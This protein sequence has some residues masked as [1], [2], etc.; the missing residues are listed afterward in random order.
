VKVTI[1]PAKPVRRGSPGY[2]R[3]LRGRVELARARQAD[4]WETVGLALAMLMAMALAWMVLKLGEPAQLRR[5]E[6]IRQAQ[7][8]QQDGWQ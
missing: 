6:M 7:E 8:V 1:Y 4:A 3:H 5:Y 2:I